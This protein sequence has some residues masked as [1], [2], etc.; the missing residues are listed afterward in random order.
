MALEK[1]TGKPDTFT[2]ARAGSLGHESTGIPIFISHVSLDAQ[3]AEKLI[4]VLVAAGIPK[5]AVRCTSVSGHKLE[6]GAAVSSE[7]CRELKECTVVI[8]LLTRSSL[9]SPYVLM[10]LGAAWGCDRRACLLLAPGVEL[11]D[12]PAPFGNVQ[13]SKMDDDHEMTALIETVAKSM[14]HSFLSDSDEVRRA[15][16]DFAACVRR[17]PDPP[18]MRARRVMR[19]ALGLAMALALAVPVLHYPWNGGGPSIYLLTGNAGGGFYRFGKWLA[20]KIKDEGYG[21][22]M[23]E[24]TQGSIDNCEQ[25]ERMEANSVGLAW[26]SIQ[27]GRSTAHPELRARV[28]A[29]LYPE[30]L[31]VLVY[32]GVESSPGEGFPDLRGKTVYL[33][34]RKSGTRTTSRLLLRAKYRSEEVD[35]LVSRNEELSQHP[36]EEA[37]NLLR[38]GKVD[39]AFFCTGLAAEAI[40]SALEDGTVRL[41]NLDRETIEQIIKNSEIEG[42]FAYASLQS[43]PD[44]STA[45]QPNPY[46]LNASGYKAK[47]AFEKKQFAFNTVAA[48]A[49]L[50]AA[51]GVDERFVETLLTILW[52]KSNRD[53][54]VSLGMPP[55]YLEHRST[56]NQRMVERG[57][58]LHPSAINQSVWWSPRVMIRRHMPSA[59]SLVAAGLILFVLLSDRHKRGSG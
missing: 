46:G 4:K 28:V 18:R 40:S 9:T 36:F 49:V 43:D 2:K 52:D 55:S 6:P 34:N 27:C 3:L 31:H 25:V 17:L 22:A 13:V 50:L 54:L 58:E 57:F 39:A 59:L 5:K 37:A 38:K 53:V 20:N 26:S 12:V 14:G 24:K 29:S 15:L 8:G 33:G 1:D 48:N 41:V 44:L 45:Y 51:N 21:G 11:S 7:I 56:L 16:R 32:T 35:E 30:A 47:Q 42:H 23:L 19:R 10:E